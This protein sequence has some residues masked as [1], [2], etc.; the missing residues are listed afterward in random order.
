MLKER[1]DPLDWKIVMNKTATMMTSMARGKKLSDEAFKKINQPVV[2]GIGSEDRMVSFEET[3]Y[4]TP[5]ST[6]GKLI[7]LEG[8]KLTIEHKEHPKLIV[9]II[10]S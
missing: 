1:H 10:S 9:Y 3:E 7:R 5:L 4:G 6:N 8:V 2:I